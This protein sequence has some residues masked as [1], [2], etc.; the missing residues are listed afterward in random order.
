MGDKDS[1]PGE[2]QPEKNVRCDTCGGA[3]PQP[4]DIF[5]PSVHGEAEYWE[6]GVPCPMHYPVPH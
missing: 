2:P 4:I 3:T 6:R 5:H 1:T